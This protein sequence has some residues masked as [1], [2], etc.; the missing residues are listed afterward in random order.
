MHF[1]LQA[2]VYAFGIWFIWTIVFAQY[3]KLS[4]WSLMSDD[5]AQPF[6]NRISWERQSLN[7]KNVLSSSARYTLP[8]NIERQIRLLM[9]AALCPVESTK[10]AVEETSGGSLASSSFSFLGTANFH[11]SQTP[12]WHSPIPI[13]HSHRLLSGFFASRG[14]SNRFWEIESR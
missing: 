5:M 6:R 10:W 12:P 8:G 14:Q 7:L 4:S 9:A 3:W 11:I 13:L 2:A 1:G